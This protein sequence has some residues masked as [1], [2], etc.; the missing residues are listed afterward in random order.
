MKLLIIYVCVYIYMYY[1]MYPFQKGRELTV[2]SERIRK[3]T[4]INA[5]IALILIIILFCI[6]N[7][8]F[9]SEHDIFFGMLLFVDAI[10][11]VFALGC[12][13]AFGDEN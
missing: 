2:F 12:F 7:S 3:L 13:I 9:I 10:S 5:S 4:I 11:S 8:N 6:G 1:Y